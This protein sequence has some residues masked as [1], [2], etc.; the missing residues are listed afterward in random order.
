MGSDQC[1]F[2]FDS[3]AGTPYGRLWEAGAGKVASANR[4]DQTGDKPTVFGAI[5]VSANFIAVSDT[6]NRRV[7]CFFRRSLQLSFIVDAPALDRM[8][9]VEE[10][11]GF[12]PW[13]CVI[14]SFGDLYVIDLGSRSVLRI[15]RRG[16]VVGIAD[17]V[18]KTNDKE[19]K[20][21]NPVSLFL[22]A[23]DNLYALDGKNGAGAPA[24][25]KKPAGPGGVWKKIAS[26]DFTAKH[27]DKRRVLGLAMG[28]RG[29]MFTGE[30]GADDGLQ[31]HCWTARGAYIGSIDNPF[32]GCKRIVAA[33]DGSVYAECEKSGIVLLNAGGD[34]AREGHFLSRVFDSGEKTTRWHRFTARGDFPPGTRLNVEYVCGDQPMGKKCRTDS[35][36]W[37]PAFEIFGEDTNAADALM[38]A[39][40]GQYLALRISLK[41]NGANTP[42]LKSIKLTYPFDSYLRYLPAVYRKDPAGRD[43][44]ERFLSLF[45][46]FNMD[47]DE[48]I[49]SMARLLD[50]AAVR[51][52]FLPW[53]ASWLGIAKEQDWSEAKFRVLLARA[54]GLFKTRGTVRGLREA[55]ELYTGAKSIVVEHFRFLRPMVLGAN[56][57][58]GVDTVAGRSIAGRLVLEE[59]STIGEFSLLEEKEPAE[60]PFT[61]DAHDFTVFIDAPEMTGRENALVRRLIERE[62]P[63]H[64]RFRLRWRG[65]GSPAIGAARVGMDTK[66]IR[67]FPPMEIGKTSVPGRDAVVGTLY[68]VGGVYGA[69]SEI[70]I[71]TFLH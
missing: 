62:K 27:H 31:F 5:A 59:S 56:S 35:L 6:A 69:R 52:D 32:G 57:Y 66:I 45:E 14:D 54:Y 64:T 70:G 39:A 9:L 67:A 22:D 34:F 37:K 23:E 2:R 61:E 17:K 55:I 60:A 18:E 28:A 12:A 53:L 49:N 13:D 25:M 36:Q 4:A 58:L 33:P 48:Q 50:P 63:A 20:I 71:D 46:S 44:A 42:L 30:C 65:D 21:D 11:A 7:Q 43:I 47:M 51:A 3:N 24:V 8:G 16:N 38:P 1:R 40:R 68:P 19:E 29:T 41:G 26:L 15:S 10:A